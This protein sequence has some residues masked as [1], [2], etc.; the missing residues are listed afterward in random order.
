MK[1]YKDPSLPATYGA[2]SK[3]IAKIP[4][5]AEVLDVGC[6]EGYLA[7]M[8]PRNRVWGLDYN[9]DAVAR[10]KQYCVD[11]SV[12]DLNSGVLGVPFGRKFDVIVFADVL[13]HLLSPDA[14]LAHAAQLLKPGGRVVV[15]LPNV[16][17]W[18]VRMNLLFGAFE[19]TDYGVLDRTHLHFYTF[20]SATEFVRTA[21]Y[22]IER[23]EGA[24][25]L[26]GPVV[27]FLPP[28]RGLLA[29][30]IVITARPASVA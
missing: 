1:R 6:S 23:V 24:A 2:L 8:L 9:P 4:P 21:G 14:V 10:A 30:N 27:H 11:A 12:V 5:E 19:Y 17:L 20:R 26:L 18:R 13:E 16:A 28:L 3:V 25:N 29:I 7:R 22:D 15:S